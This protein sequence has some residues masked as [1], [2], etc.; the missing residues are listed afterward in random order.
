MS[1][2]L[3]QPVGT[4][5]HYDVQEPSLFL[6]DDVT[7]VDLNGTV[8]LLRTD[9]GLLAT[10]T[11]ACATR[12]Q[13]SRCLAEIQ[14]PLRLSFQEEYLPTLD[15]LTGA[16]MSLPDGTDNFRIDAV[17]V[18]NLD[19]ALRQYKLMS[20]PLNPLCRPDCRGLCPR[21]GLNL[22]ERSCKCPPQPDSRWEAL[23]KLNSALDAGERS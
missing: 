12:Q 14:H 10:V 9:M 16:P 2:E 21:C 22:N 23:A 19:E 17:Y 3:R 4:Q 18:L 7:L 13:C 8:E 6:D 11:V 20:E 1:Q 15:V 5:V